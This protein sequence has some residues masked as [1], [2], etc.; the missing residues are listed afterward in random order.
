MYAAE[1]KALTASSS[2]HLGG[3]AV[4]LAVVAAVSSGALAE[5]ASAIVAGSEVV[6]AVFAVCPW[7]VA[8]AT[9]SASA[10]PQR[11]IARDGLAR[12]GTTDTRTTTDV[13][14][15]ISTSLG[16]KTKSPAFIDRNAR[17]LEMSCG[18]RS[19]RLY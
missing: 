16:W 17:V 11:Q 13:R 7:A 12:D 18:S 14:C 10:A 19:W 8:T 3:A 6:A 2:Y 15:I 5:S 9:D 4:A 1:T